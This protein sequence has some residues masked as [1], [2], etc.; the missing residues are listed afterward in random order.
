MVRS[1]QEEEGDTCP[2]RGAHSAAA[3]GLMFSEGHWATK[4]L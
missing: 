3:V 1:G 4:K 2:A